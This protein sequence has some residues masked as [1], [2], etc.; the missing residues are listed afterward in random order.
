[1]TLAAITSPPIASSALP[2]DDVLAEIVDKLS[3]HNCLV[4]VAPPGAGKT[5]RVPLELLKA[6]FLQPGKIIIA[7]PRR[8]AARAA[9]ERMAASL[10]EKVGETVGLRVRLQTQV[11][12]K[13]RIE[14]VTE[15]VFS[16][17]ILDDPSLSGI[18][19]VIFD[20]FHERSLDADMGLALARDAQQGLREDLRLMVMS[21][22]LDGARIA[23]ALGGAPVIESAGRMHDIITH[24]V[25]RDPQMRIEEAMTRTILRALQEETGS[26]LAFLPGQA[27]ILR[28]AGLLAERIRDPAIEIAPLYGALERG[29]QDRAVGP[30]P[31]GRRKVVLA[32][33]IAET[34]LTIEG[35]RVVVD[36]GLSRVPIYE[37]DL[38]LT[39]FATIRASRAA[40]NQRRG[41]AG[42]TEAGV[43]YRLWERAASGG[44]TAFDTPEIL[45]A[46]L[47]GLVLDLAAWGVR[48]PAQL[49]WL[50][51]PPATSLK[52]A[53]AMLVSLDAL[54]AD[55][56]LTATGKAMRALPLP[57]RLARMVSAAAPADRG[58]AAHIAM[59]MVE[60][61]LGGT[62]LDLA[63]RVEAFA[64]DN[65]QRAREARKLAGRWGNGT[66]HADY[67]HC[68]ALLAL[69]FPDRIAKARGKP[70]EFLMRNGRAAQMEPHEALAKAPFL[71]IG[72]IAGRAGASRILLC[73]ELS[74]EDI[75][76]IHSGEVQWSDEVFLDPGSLALRGRRRQN[77]G[78]LMLGEQ[79]IAV[80]AS[81]ANASL[82]AQGIGKAGLDRLPISKGLAQ[83]RQRVGFLRK[84][85]G[86]PWPDLSD[87]ALAPTAAQWLTPFIEDCTSLAAISPEQV[88]AALHALLD[89]EL[90][91][92]LALE[93][94]THYTTPAGASHALDYEGDNAP[95]LAV[96]VQELFG[97]ATHPTIAGG[98]IAI[99]LE[100][101]SPA[102]RP[103]QITRDLPGFWH[104]SWA[105]V[106]SEMK[107]RYPRHVWPDRPWEAAPTTRA[108]PRGT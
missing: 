16:R 85:Q 74:L 87:E 103:V 92:R 79:N 26:I 32:T 69:A 12:A 42:R 107:G 101:L 68:G 5:T 84:A 73:A 24:Y 10:G 104:G 13:T 34:S 37:P 47:S 99:T 91:R 70:G 98:K 3:G 55:L 39:R 94:P 1:M 71:A 41:R 52:E 14:V 108:K 6:P 43:C 9:A 82:L 22:T 60:R 40:V 11:S 56:R 65:S 97:L 19:T 54:D 96:R 67:G 17:M 45:S 31:K 59:V 2:I 46:D 80:Q 77:F 38:A 50:D 27:E 35:V 76:A 66:G 86:A 20:E 90:A 89:W 29:M 81:A 78:A 95:K 21:A 18:A 61:G 58:L 4:L 15:G 7:E 88:D 25:G 75:L 63:S 53:R 51:P 49:V 100:L 8:L 102:Y 62:S 44:L 28:C 23:Q 106:K 30:V 72:E 36:S 33:S 48:D 105:S 93:A 57:P 64:R 83:W